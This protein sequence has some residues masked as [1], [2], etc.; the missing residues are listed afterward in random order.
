LTLPAH[1]E[2][3]DRTVEGVLH[4]NLANGE[5]PVSDSSGPNPLKTQ[6]TGQYEQKRMTIRDARRVPDLSLE[7]HGFVL[8]PHVTK[9]KDFYDEDEIRQVYYPEID[10]LVSSE[11]GAS[12]VLIF[13]YTLRCGDEARGVRGP[14][15]RVHNDYTDWS[16]PQRVRDLVPAA[17]AEELLRHRVAVIQVWRPIRNPVRCSPLALID[18]Q[19]IASEDLVPTER[20]H[21]DRVGEIY[22]LVFNPAHR[23]FYFPDMERDEAIL[24]KCYDSETDGRSRFTP[25]SAFEDATVPPDAPPR[26]SIEVR[27]LV[28]WAPARS[29]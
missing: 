26:E 9:V 13:D 22:H 1:E 7:Q 11:T 29:G 8:R 5:K 12:R 19:S 18:A 2:Q 23:W 14:V 15:Q 6:H 20:R 27:A 4:Y 3:R 10:A 17:E 21:P 28:F 25:H 16:G 24:F